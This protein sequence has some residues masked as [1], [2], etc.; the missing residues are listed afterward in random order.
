[1]FV[2]R[3]R[4][5]TDRLRYLHSL[6]SRH[7]TLTDPSPVPGPDTVPDHSSLSHPSDDS[8]NGCDR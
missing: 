2:C 8:G 6:L 7:C 5:L 3:C 1:M 4:T